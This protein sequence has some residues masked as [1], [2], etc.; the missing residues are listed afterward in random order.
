MIKLKQLLMESMDVERF[1][2]N[3]SKANTFNDFL[4]SLVGVKLKD[5]LD[6]NSFMSLYLMN[7][8]GFS[9]RDDQDLKVLYFNLLE[10]TARFI[11]WRKIGPLR[12]KIDDID[13]AEDNTPEFQEYR[14]KLH[15]LVK[16]I[17]KAQADKNME[18]LPKLRAEK[19]ALINPK[20]YGKN[21]EDMDA[22][23]KEF[24]NSKLG[25]H[26]VMPSP[27]D[28]PEDKEAYKKAEEAFIAFKNRMLS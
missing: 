5:L 16:Q 22:I 14:K 1:K 4:K 23:V 9:E 18:I 20:S 27:D 24:H 17:I 6:V 10:N 25:I 13:A 21:M 2:P 8:Y 15:S 11:N 26:D 7:K 19:S 3:L 28:R 12:K